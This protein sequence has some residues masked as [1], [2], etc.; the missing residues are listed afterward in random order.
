VKGMARLLKEC[1]EIEPW[2]KFNSMREMWRVSLYGTFSFHISIM[3][4]GKFTTVCN[5]H[6]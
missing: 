3:I 1:W 2:E 5:V 4:G 6:F